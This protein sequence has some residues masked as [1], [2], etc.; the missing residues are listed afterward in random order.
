MMVRE[1]L[2]LSVFHGERDR[3]GRGLLADALIDMYMRSEV[4]AAALLRGVEGFGVRHRLQTDRL[5]T[6]SE[7][8]PMVAVAVDTPDRIQALTEEV[9]GVS[10]HGL[11]ALERVRL[12]EDPRAALAPVDPGSALGLTVFSERG[13][14]AGGLPAHIAAVELLHSLGC[15]GASVLLGVDGAVAGERRRA[16]LLAANARVPLVINAVG[17]PDAL[18]AALPELSAMLG[19][20]LMT[21]ER[22]RVVKRDGALLADPAERSGFDRGG[23]AYWQKLTVQTGEQDRHERRPIHAALVRRLR[24]AGAAG[25]TALRAQWGYGGDHAPHGER[26][27]AIGRHAPVLTVLLDTPENMRRWFSIVDE[28]TASTGLVTSELVPALR[29]AGPGIEHGGL[30]LA[31]PRRG[32]RP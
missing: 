14:R 10:R 23:L 26:L 11:I 22:V 15:S 2:K 27:R 17:R 21:V 31:A 12:L 29:A 3:A 25:A 9:R 24:R 30:R 7:D 32:P 16:R 20:P 8:L 4:R 13:R 6:L 1:G 18:A 5:L 19:G 28:M